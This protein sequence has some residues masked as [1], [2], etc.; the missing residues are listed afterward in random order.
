MTKAEF[1]VL[2]QKVSDGTANDSELIIYSRYFD[3]YQQAGN[4]WNTEQ[5]GDKNLIYAKIKEQINKE[6]K[7]S[8]SILFWR[9]F[10]NVAAAA[11]IL[12]SISV[13]LYFYSVKNYDS[14]EELAKHPIPAGKNK[15]FL[16]L[17]N[18]K[19]IDLDDASEGSL[20]KEA[21]VLISKKSNGNIVYTMTNAALQSTNS[22][23]NLHTLSTPRGGQ[24]QIDLPDGTKVWLNATSSLTFPAVFDSLKDRVVNLSGEAYFEVSHRDKQGFLVKT[25]RQTVQVMGTHF[26]VNGYED[27]SAT[28]TTLLNG[29]VK[30]SSP[31]ESIII[32]PGE[33]AILASYKLH[34]KKVDTNDVMDWKN[35]EFIFRNENIYTIMRKISRW[36][37]VNV[38]FESNVLSTETFS[39]SVSRYDNISEILKT[40]QLTDKVHFKI[41]QKKI[42]VMN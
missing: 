30:V 27:E 34:T 41:E 10:I 42:I 25:S 17:A 24:F 40:L 1:G 22:K 14:L 3:A 37:D 9:K 21:G 16:K 6:I 7:P 2:I 26:N 5:I 11:I 23:P 29:S 15:A 8:L 13:G 28:R 20:L 32:K 12:S 39:G 4:T 19:I 36:Y 18:G 33:Q 38:F 35:G 31:N